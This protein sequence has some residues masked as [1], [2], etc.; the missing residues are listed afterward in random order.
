MTIKNYISIKKFE[1]VA[2]A[3]PFFMILIVGFLDNSN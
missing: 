2:V 1:G 3:M